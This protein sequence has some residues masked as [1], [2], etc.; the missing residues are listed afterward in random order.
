[1]DENSLM[2]M[3]QLLQAF[4]SQNSDIRTAAED[5]YFN[6]LDNDPNSTINIL[7]AFILGHPSCSERKHALIRVKCYLYRIN[8]EERNNEILPETY[9]N[10]ASCITQ[11]LQESNADNIEMTYIFII[12]NLLIKTLVIPGLWPSIFDTMWKL[13]S[14][15]FVSKV[16]SFFSEYASFYTFQNINQINQE[17]LGQLPQLVKFDYPDPEARVSSMSLAYNLI[18]YNPEF[19]QI[20]GIIPNAINELRDDLIDSSINIFD[21]FFQNNWKQIGDYINGFIIIFLQIAQNPERSESCRISSLE[22]LTK[23]LNGPSHI[24][25]FLNENIIMFLQALSSCFMINDQ[26]NSVYTTAT[27]LFEC[28]ASKPESQ[29]IVL[30]QITPSIS[31]LPPQVVSVFLMYIPNIQFINQIIEF[32]Q[33]PDSVISKNAFETISVLLKK[34][35]QKLVKQNPDIIQAISTLLFKFVD[36]GRVDALIPLPQLAK[37]LGMYDKRKLDVIAPKL[38]EICNKI[39]NSDSIRCAAAVAEAF[40]EKVSASALDFANSSMKLILDNADPDS[41]LYI[42]IAVSTFAKCM[43]QDDL[44]QFVLNLMKL[45][46]EAPETSTYDGLRIIAKQIGPQFAQFL[47]IFM[48]YLIQIATQKVVIFIQRGNEMTY[49]PDY[50]ILT[51]GADKML[52]RIEQL[53]EIA[54]ALEA[55][56][57]YAEA[58]GSAFEPFVEQAFNAANTTFDI[59]YD[60]EIRVASVKLFLSLTKCCPQII[61]NIFNLLLKKIA[62]KDQ[63]LDEFLEV[64]FREAI[65]TALQDIVMNEHCSQEIRVQYL[66]T[67][68]GI[69]KTTISDIRQDIKED[70]FEEFE[71]N[72][73]NLLW[74]IAIAY[75]FLYEASPNESG[76]SF[77]Q[78]SNILLPFNQEPVLLILQFSMAMW[79][80]FLIFGP[81]NYVEQCQ[82]MVP[83]VMEMVNHKDKEIRRMALYAI[84]RICEKKNL[85]AEEIDKILSIL[86]LSATSEAAQN[87]ESL[88]EGND[89]ALSSYAILLKK[90]VP[91]KNAVEDIQHFIEM[92]PAEDE[93]DEVKIAYEYL[94]ELFWEAGKNEEIAGLIQPICEKLLEGIQIEVISDIVKSVINEKLAQGNVP[95]QVSQFLSAFQ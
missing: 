70:E 27:D 86:Y 17:V 65:M 44:H 21:G 56:S 18:K 75:K 53:S 88:F 92:F 79:T 90:R 15:P 84:G 10:I 50:T 67:I 20:L 46:Q 78:I 3:G 71:D 39:P 93:L 31:S 74:T 33:S 29:N 36:A 66:Q 1:M 48:P 59:V 85:P 14:T 76:A 37:T 80:D 6:L 94:F 41:T 42:M 47:P 49:A 52:F 77:V 55:I 45:V 23:L 7:F 24:R 82:A 26:E 83:Q 91:M 19:I 69:L 73:L 43:P 28:F 68:P 40:P 13:L 51:K 62:E 5:N 25:R 16:I 30:S 61:N 9:Q 57:D 34:N 54:G 35:Y 2:K 64:P 32:A 8:I 22:I 72:Y 87:D 12:S 60:T 4:S 95:P 63:H 58:V 11:L 38:L 89:N 81:E